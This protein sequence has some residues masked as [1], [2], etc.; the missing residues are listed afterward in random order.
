MLLGCKTARRKPNP[1]PNTAGMCGH[2]HKSVSVL[3]WPWVLLGRKTHN[4][5][6]Q[7][8]HTNTHGMCAHY[9]KSLPVLIWPWVLLGRKTH[10]NNKQNSHTNTHGM[11]AHYLKS[12]PVLIWPWVLLGRKTH[13]NNK[14]THTPTH[15]ACARTVTCW[16]PSKYHRRCGLDVSNNHKTNKYSHTSD[17][18][19]DM[20]LDVSRM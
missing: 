14:Q 2:C 16:Y 17:T 11:C 3:V 13:M 1:H 6:K 15:M 20:T 5:N 18:H 7:N 8:S 12:L 4:N 19:P 10:N 9:L